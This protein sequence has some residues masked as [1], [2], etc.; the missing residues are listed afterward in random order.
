MKN[1]RGI[2]THTLKSYLHMIKDTHTDTHMNAS[3]NY[4]GR[5]MKNMDRLY[6]CQFPGRGICYSFA[7]CYL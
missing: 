1:L 4:N 3:K 6:E 5:N 7:R 2:G